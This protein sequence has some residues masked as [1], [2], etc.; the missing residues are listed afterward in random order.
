AGN[1]LLEVLGGRATHPVSPR[2]GGFSK[3][4][5]VARLRTLRDALARSLDDALATV[6]WATTLPMP[7]LDVPYV[8]VALDA[9]TYPL[10]RGVAMLVD[11]AGTVERMPI[12]RWDEVFVERRVPHSNAMQATLHDGTTYLTGPA[13]RLHHHAE[14]LH[15]RARE[16]MDAIG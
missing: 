11:R 5:T 12:E 2:I 3:A 9:A 6:T 7:E 10:E 15:P 1:A 8:F 4:P 13:A 14:K 16:A